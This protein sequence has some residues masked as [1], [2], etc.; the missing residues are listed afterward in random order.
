MYLRPHPA[1][2][3]VAIEGGQTAN[4]DNEEYQ[5]L[6]QFEIKPTNH[7]QFRLNFFNEPPQKPKKINSDRLNTDESNSVSLR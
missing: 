1:C 5:L 3:V 7:H 4:I 6:T 2:N